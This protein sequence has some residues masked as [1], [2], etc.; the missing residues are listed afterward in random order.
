[1]EDSSKHDTFVI[2]GK[3]NAQRQLA[4]L[5]NKVSYAKAIFELV[6][7]SLD[8]GA[9]KI[10][11]VITADI[12][13]VLDN[14]IGISVEKAKNL[15]PYSS[16]KVNDIKSI[17]RYGV[18][19]HAGAYKLGK[20]LDIVSCHQGVHL[21]VAVD[22]STIRDLSELG[23]GSILSEEEIAQVNVNSIEPNRGTQIQITDLQAE[24][25][26]NLSDPNESFV[27]KLMI[28]YGERILASGVTIQVNGIVVESFSIVEDA[29]ILFDSDVNDAELYNLPLGMRLVVAKCNP[30]PRMLD[31]YKPSTENR[32][33]HIYV[34]N[35][36]VARALNSAQFGFS[37]S[38]DYNYNPFRILLFANNSTN[39]A[40]FIGLNS[41]KEI[42]HSALTVRF[43]EVLRVITISIV[44]PEALK[45]K[46]RR[47]ANKAGVVRKKQV[48]VKPEFFV[49]ALKK[50]GK[51]V[52]ITADTKKGEFLVGTSF[53]SIQSTL[54]TPMPKN[55]P[56]FYAVAEQIAKGI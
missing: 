10:S 14:G 2:G 55:K 38:G 20:K 44:K 34:N 27:D 53:A 52:V 54:S 16:D 8:A 48:Q 11:I 4:D 51:L 17:G 7:N 49:H 13:V 41:N 3:L 33:L 31:H 29:D 35:R 40:N 12:I 32:G 6:D 18:G 56:S 30:T 50:N 36:M 1:M 22:Y 23:K 19:L 15:I 46:K 26:E 28:R 47:S 5:S 37:V 43:K 39:H 42:T 9:S 25:Y 24:A 45:E 21:G